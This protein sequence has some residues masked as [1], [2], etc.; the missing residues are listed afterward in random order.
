MHLHIAGYPDNKPNGSMWQQCCQAL[1]WQLQGS[2]LWHSCYVRGG[3]SGSP[4]WIVWPPVAQKGTNV[5]MTSSATEQH[6]SSHHGSSSI[7]AANGKRR[8]SA[9]G[10]NNATK[11]Q[12]GC[13]SSSSSNNIMQQQHDSSTVFSRVQVIAVHTSSLKIPKGDG[14]AAYAKAAYATAIAAAADGSNI[15][16]CSAIS[17][18]SV[19]QNTA[20]S[21]AAAGSTAGVPVQ[22]DTAKVTSPMLVTALPVSIVADTRP[23]ST[24]SS[25]GSSAS[26]RALLA[27]AGGHEDDGENVLLPVAVP[28]TG[29]SYRWI[30]KVLDEHQCTDG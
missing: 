16:G 8:L 24:H 27:G 23:S 11:Q 19:Q 3:N 12:R 1:D 21:D 28:F 15:V 14:L 5:S 7:W 17:S 30:L 25:S 29:D 10:C 4:V 2:L 9:T 20:Q 13:F 26:Q 18:G 22:S 6:S